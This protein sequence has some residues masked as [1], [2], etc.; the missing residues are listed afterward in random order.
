MDWMVND[1][2]YY[3]FL[4]WKLKCENILEH[5]LAAIPECQKCKG[6]ITWSGNFGMGQ[7]ISWG[8][9]C[10]VHSWVEHKRTQITVM[11]SR[12]KVNGE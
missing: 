8:L 6:V 5:E 12:V 7:F 2:L 10:I 11:S 3:R 4:K 1:T 9:L